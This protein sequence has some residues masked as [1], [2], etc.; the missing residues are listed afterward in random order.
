MNKQSINVCKVVC[1]CDR[2][3][4]VLFLIQELDKEHARA[5]ELV[6]MAAPIKF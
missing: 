5:L 4:F 2:T 6:A 1:D 3:V